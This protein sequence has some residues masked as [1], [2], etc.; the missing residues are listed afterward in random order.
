MDL[1]VM[2]IDKTNVKEPTE[3]DG[4]WAYKLN[5]FIPKRLNFKDFM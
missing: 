5:T 4:F 3:R 1:R 2:I